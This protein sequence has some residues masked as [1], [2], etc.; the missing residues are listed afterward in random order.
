M[1]SYPLKEYYPGESCPMLAVALLTSL[2]AVGVPRVESLPRLDPRDSPHNVSSGSAIRATSA[3]SS[4]SAFP[5]GVADCNDGSWELTTSNYERFMMDTN[6]RTW[7]NGDSRRQRVY[8]SRYVCQRVSDLTCNSWVVTRKNNDLTE[9][10]A[11][12]FGPVGSEQQFICTLE[13]GTCTPA[14]GCN[15]EFFPP[16]IDS[17]RVI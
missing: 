10:L 16:F 9:S 6:S 14:Q 1:V 3:T 17:S 7:Y 2:L 8:V 13:T 4:A 12:T 5:T 15:S 11:S